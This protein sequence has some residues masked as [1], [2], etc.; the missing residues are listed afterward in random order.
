MFIQDKVKRKRRSDPDSTKPK[1]RWRHGTAHMTLHDFFHQ[2]PGTVLSWDTIRRHMG[3][4]P[5][6]PCFGIDLLGPVMNYQ[7]MQQQQIH[8]FDSPPSIPTETTVEQKLLPVTRIRSQCNSCRRRHR[9]RCPKRMRRR[10]GA[11]RNRHLSRNNFWDAEEEEEEGEEKGEEEEEDNVF[12]SIPRRNR[13]V[14]VAGAEKK[15]VT[16]TAINPP[17]RRKKDVVQ[18]VVPRTAH[19]SYCWMRMRLRRR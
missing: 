16:A 5:A 12:K 9:V 2:R 17:S 8:A 6:F 13:A 1:I 14:V 11:S 4:M 15:G 18:K 7:Q 19:S 10:P 3:A